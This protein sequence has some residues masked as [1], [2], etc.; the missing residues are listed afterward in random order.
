[1]A[2][3]LANLEASCVSDACGCFSGEEIQQ[4]DAEQ[5]Y[6]QAMSKGTPT[7]LRLPRHIWS[8]DRN[9]RGFHDPVLPTK[10]ALYRR[11]NA[12]ASW[13]QQAEADLV[14]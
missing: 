7:F 10:L 13:E 8:D 11:P 12:G 1:M 3:Q 5:A 6:A 9:N 14:T 2:S 4:A